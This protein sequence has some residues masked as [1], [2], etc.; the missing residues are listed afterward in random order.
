MLALLPN[1][2]VDSE[3]RRSIARALGALGNHS[4][5]PQ[6]L[7]LLQDTQMNR[8]VRRSIASALGALGDCSLV[9]PLLALLQDTQVHSY[10]RSSIAHALGALGASEEQIR[11]MAEILPGSDML[12]PIYQAL[13]KLSRQSGV[14][15]YVS[16]NPDVKQVNVI[17]VSAE[18]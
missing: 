11:V 5:A 16:D 2:W 12:D 7:A 1:E 3:V 14:R 15:I 13:W 6:L 4:P 8:R 9:P 10:V 17:R 18:A